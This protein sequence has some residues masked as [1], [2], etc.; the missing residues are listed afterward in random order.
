MTVK[1]V[2]TLTVNNRKILIEAFNNI[3]SHSV[4]ITEMPSTLFKSLNYKRSNPDEYELV[5]HEKR[6]HPEYYYPEEESS[7]ASSG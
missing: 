5:R 1:K 2:L 7:K 6:Y 4:E 3:R